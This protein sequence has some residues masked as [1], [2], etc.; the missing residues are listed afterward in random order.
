VPAAIERGAL[1]CAGTPTGTIASK[2]LS[3]CRAARGARS[4][5]KRLNLS[6]ASM[7]ARQQ[8]GRS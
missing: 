1:R 6:T 3:S 7:N 8:A 4:A 2:S 5:T